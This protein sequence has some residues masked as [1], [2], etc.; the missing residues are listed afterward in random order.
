M[1]GMKAFGV[2]FRVDRPDLYGPLSDIFC[3]LKH[4][5]ENDEFGSPEDWK[6]KLDPQVVARLFNLTADERA[7]DHH[8]RS[9]HVVVVTPP[10]DAVGSNW[11]FGAILDSV[12]MGDYQL[13]AV[14]ARGDGTAELQIDPHGYPYGGIGAF[15]GMLEAHGMTVLGVNECGAYEPVA[16]EARRTKKWWQFWQ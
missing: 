12:D 3:A 15:I 7:H 4:A 6:A 8:M 16:R 5:K 2:H 14:T 13:S 9:T 11:D 10:Q 1:D